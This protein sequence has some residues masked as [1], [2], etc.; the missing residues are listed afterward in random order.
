MLALVRQAR[1]GLC[2]TLQNRWTR[3]FMHVGYGAK[4][5]LYGLIGLFALKNALVDAT[6]TTEAGSEAV[7]AALTDYPAG[8]LILG[9]FG[10]G[11]L[12]YVLWRIVQASLDPA[13]SEQGHLLRVVQRCGYLV[14]GLTYLGV[15][16]TAE[17]LA[18]GLTIERD[19]TIEDIAS[20]LFERAI[21]PWLF[22]GAGV[23]VVGVGLTYV[24]GAYSG[25]YISEFRSSLPKLGRRLINFIGRVGIAARGVGF[26]LIGVHLVM[27][28][29]LIEDDAAGGLGDI[30]SQLDQRSG[31][32]AWLMAIGLGFIA[33]AVYM[34]VAAIY[35]RFPRAES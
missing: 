23:A 25:S 13:H 15:A 20:I 27:S 11:L 34:A 29:Y 24:Y 32:D 30:L 8:N 3:G 2:W 22:M 1:G 10:I 4:G 18:I 9:L 6:S 14:S 26:I 19:D 16:F 5:L 35:R 7:L 21:G 28:A 31:G 12:G 33:Y 17:R